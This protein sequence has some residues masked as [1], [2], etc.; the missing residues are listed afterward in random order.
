MAGSASGLYG[1]GGGE[2]SVT[3]KKYWLI[4]KLKT[5]SEAKPQ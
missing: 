1:S 3:I 2:S 5:N 4:P